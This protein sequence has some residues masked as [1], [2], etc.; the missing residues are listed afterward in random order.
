[1]GVDGQGVPSHMLIQRS[2]FVRNGKMGCSQDA[3]EWDRMDSRW[4]RCSCLN[5][6][7]YTRSMNNV[8]YPL[9]PSMPVHVLDSRNG[10]NPQIILTL[11]NSVAHGVMTRL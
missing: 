7:I 9:F 1:M 5:G 4:A 11:E 10:G 2:I 8:K 6:C 3:M